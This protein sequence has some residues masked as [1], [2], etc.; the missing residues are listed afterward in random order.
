MQGQPISSVSLACTSEKNM[1]G[2]L[3]IKRT[4]SINFDLTGHYVALHRDS[5][6]QYQYNLILRET[7]SLVKI[8]AI[9]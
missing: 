4:F 2:K 7:K 5:L 9:N 8:K 1:S 3:Y 6:Y